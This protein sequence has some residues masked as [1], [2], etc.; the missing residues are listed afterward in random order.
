ML[1][2]K[3][4]SQRTR[5][6]WNE[7]KMMPS[8]EMNPF[9]QEEEEDGVSSSSFDEEEKMEDTS[10]E[11]TSEEQQAPK[12]EKNVPVLAEKET[13]L[14]H[15]TKFL[16]YTVLLL[17]AGA[18]AFGTY[19]FADRAEQNDFE[20]QVSHSHRQN[21]NTWHAKVAHELVSAISLV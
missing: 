15:R 21:L 12:K 7:R 5:R 6:K 16:V 3:L 2:N 9:H 4:S 1:H 14:V 20:Q 10:G 18:A 17:V 13:R 19:W 11:G 8:P